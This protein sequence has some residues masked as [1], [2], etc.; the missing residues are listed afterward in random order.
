[1]RLRMLLKVALR[2]GHMAELV[3]DVGVLDGAVLHTV[4]IVYLRASGLV[5]AYIL[6]ALQD[7]ETHEGEVQTWGSSA[8]LRERKIVRQ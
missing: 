1:M 3:A 8:L 7:R 5:G 4:L 2:R 6:A